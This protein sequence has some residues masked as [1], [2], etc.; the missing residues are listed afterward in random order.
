MALNRSHF[1][2]GFTNSSSSNAY[3]FPLRP[4]AVVVKTTTHSDS[5]TRGSAE[6]V[7][8]IGEEGFPSGYTEEGSKAYAPEE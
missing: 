6:S 1:E 8:A 3:R 5:H 7:I 4:V 2:T